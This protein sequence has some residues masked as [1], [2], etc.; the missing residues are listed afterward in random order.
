M[1]EISGTDRWPGLFS[2]VLKNKGF[3]SSFIYSFSLLA[4]VKKTPRVLVITEIKTII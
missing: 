3:Y 2:R 1:T 4:N